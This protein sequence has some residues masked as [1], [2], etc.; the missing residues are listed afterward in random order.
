MSDP[1]HDNPVGPTLS[2]HLLN[3]AACAGL[4]FI[5]FSFSIAVVVALSPQSLRQ[6]KAIGLVPL[7]LILVFNVGAMLV[8][9]M[10]ASKRTREHR[11]APEA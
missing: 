2:W 5:A 6:S 7:F 11:A 1:R 4:W 9:S 3:A 8:A 10:R